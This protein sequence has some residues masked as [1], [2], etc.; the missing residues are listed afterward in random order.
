MITNERKF[1]IK[2]ILDSISQAKY[3]QLKTTLRI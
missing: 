2:S 3:M 1:N